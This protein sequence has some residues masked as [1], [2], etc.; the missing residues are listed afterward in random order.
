MRRLA[1]LLSLAAGCASGPRPAS[2]SERSFARPEAD[3]VRLQTLDVVVV[4]AGPPRIAGERFEVRGFDPPQLD[5]PLIAGAED[6]A[7]RDALLHALAKRLRASGYRVQLRAAGSAEA[8]AE[9]P[10]AVTSTLAGSSTAAVAA[11]PTPGE[12]RSREPVSV[13]TAEQTLRDVLESSR[14]DGVLV[15]RVVPVDELTIDEGTGTRFEDTPLGREQVRDYKP[16]RKEG[17]VLVGQAFLFDRSSGLR[18]W[19][20][21]APSFPDDG[22]LTPRH[23]FLSFGFLAEGAAPGDKERAER[24]AERFTAAMLTGFP[25]AKA[26]DPEARLALDALDPERERRV[27]AFLDVSHWVFGLD[28]GY[29][30]E[31]AKLDVSLDAQVIDELDAGAILPSGLLRL[32]PRVEY[33]STGAFIFGIAVPISYAPSSFGRTYHRDNPAPDLMDPSDRTTHVS[34]GGVTSYGLELLAGR[35]ISA[36]DKLAIVPHAGAFAE[37]WRIERE[38]A[39]SVS[40]GQH[41]RIGGQLGGELWLRSSSAPF[42]RIG[43]DGR[44]GLDLEG[45]VFVGLGL[46]LGVGLLL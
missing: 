44:V 5:Q 38:P 1:L 14:A 23:P 11:A 43:L 12:P 6:A 34:V 10:P 9:V 25:A 19:S 22:R 42:G 17:R 4:S 26:G 16:V 33:L 24:A 41:L 8:P 40:S 2:I 28:A 37:F 32:R 21:Q 18:L 46:T 36:G 31:Q 35:F 29:G 13:L 7:T 20:R 39:S 15:V 3:R 45:G 30:F 27:Q